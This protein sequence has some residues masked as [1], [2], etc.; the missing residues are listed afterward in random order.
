M[1]A[2]L[3]SFYELSR[4]HL[5]MFAEKI[6]SSFFLSE[7]APLKTAIEKKSTRSVT[8]IVPLFGRIENFKRFLGVYDTLTR[9]DSDLKLIVSLSGDLE[10]R[11]ALTDL[12]RHRVQNPCSGAVA[13]ATLRSATN[14]K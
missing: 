6:S 13:A 14:K 1:N 2:R 4:W 3:R 11:F 8:L 7:P 12:I 5:T 10:E 9:T